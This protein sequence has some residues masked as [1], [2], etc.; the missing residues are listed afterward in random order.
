MRE[1]LLALL[2]AREGHFRY[3][4]GHH[5]SLWLEIPRLY[6]RPDRL[7]PLAA[8]L[9]RR[10]AEHDIEAVCGPLVEGALL[11]QMVAEELGAE[12][13]FAEQLA[14]P[15]GEG[16]YPVV[17]RIPD[18]LRPFLLGKRTA[19]VDDVINAGSAVRGALAD[20]RACGARPVALG[21]LLVL[22]PSASALAQHEGLP[23]ERLSDL[24]STLWEPSACPLCHS[25]VPLEGVP[26]GMGRSP[27]SGDSARPMRPM[28][29]P[30]LTIGR[31]LALAAVL[32]TMVG[33]DVVGRRRQARFSARM[34]HHEFAASYSSEMS[35]TLERWAEESAARSR[36]RHNSAARLAR[37]GRQEEAQQLRVQAR[38]EARTSAGYRAKNKTQRAL[39]EYHERLRR[40]YRWAA[41]I[42]LLPVAADPPEPK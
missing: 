16:L 19:V 25:G 23:L 13:A 22:G 33:L 37:E 24:P 7:R 4:S 14:A 21:T 10:L 32:A 42:P 36:D 41:A 8:E 20:V 34:W 40:K 9:A 31:M 39:A 17:Y 18:P 26:E 35:S 29:L 27:A 15:R 5:G 30:R 11:A 6:L 38:A 1:D 28:R 3:E 12:F 2:A